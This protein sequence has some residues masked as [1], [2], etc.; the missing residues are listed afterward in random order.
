MESSVEDPYKG[1]GSE[2]LK[3]DFAIQFEERAEYRVRVEAYFGKSSAYTGAESLNGG[4]FTITQKQFVD[5]SDKYVKG[6]TNGIS[7]DGMSGMMEDIIDI[8]NA[9]VLPIVYVVASAFL[10]IKGTL[11]GVQIVKSAD[12]SSLRQEKIGALKWLVIG[13]AITYAATTIIGLL[14][15]FFETAF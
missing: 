2:L 14:T 10:V 4:S 7:D 15:G 8:V 1:N 9:A 3:Y 13:V 6:T 5:T 11:L 12:D